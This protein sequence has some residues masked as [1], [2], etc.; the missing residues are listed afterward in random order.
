M[1]I[2]P[3][4]ASSSSMDRDSAESAPPESANNTAKTATARLNAMEKV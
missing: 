3:T 1:K 4:F 2:R